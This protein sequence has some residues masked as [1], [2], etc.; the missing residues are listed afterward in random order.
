MDA[1]AERVRQG[2]RLVALVQRDEGID[3]GIIRLLLYGKAFQHGLTGGGIGSGLF[4]F[5]D[6]LRRGRRQLACFVCPFLSVQH[7][8]TE[9]QGGEKELSIHI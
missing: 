9:K 7:R 4:I 2:I 3:A 5:P 8:R 6:E 1:Q